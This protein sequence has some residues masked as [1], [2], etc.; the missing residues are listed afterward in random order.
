MSF[1]TP[2]RVRTREEVLPIC[3]SW[4][5]KAFHALERR[6]T[7]EENDRNVESES[8]HGVGKQHKVSDV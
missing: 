2:E 1:S 7:Y 3:K 6:I 8:N 5:S 4:V